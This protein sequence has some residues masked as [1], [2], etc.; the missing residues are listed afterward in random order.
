M[1]RTLNL[2][3]LAHVDAGKTTLTER[4]LHTAGVIDEVGSVDHG[5]THTDTLALERRR[6]ITIRSAVVSF[7]LGDVTVNLVDTPGHSDFIAEVERALA[8]LDGAVLVVSA[9]EGVQAQTRVLMRVLHRLGIPTLV[10]VNKVDRAGARPEAVLAQIADRLTPD[11]VALGEVIG[12]GT[13]GARVE[14]APDT[15]PVTLDRLAEVLTRHDD[16]LL[17]AWLGD[18]GAGDGVA[19][20]RLRA[21]LA[22]QTA[23]VRVH[24]VLFGSAATGAGVAELMAALTA[25]LPT[26]AGDADG[27]VSGTVFKVERGP[28]GE[29]LAWVRMFSGT[30][31]VRDRLPV[32][33]AEARV[34]GIRV[35][36]DG[37]DVVSQAL[38][39]G[40]VGVLTGLTGARVGDAV[41]MPWAGAAPAHHFSPPSLEAVVE[42]CD[43]RRRAA[44]HAALTELCEQD[45]MV[46]L[47]QDD[48]RRELSVSLYGEVQ[49]EVLAATLADDYGVPVGF[50][51]TTPLC[52]ERVLGAGAAFELI[53]VDP[54]PFLATVGLA[55]EPAPV[56]HGVDFRLGVELG[57]MPPAFFTAVEG[58]LRETLL[59]GLH[60]WAVPDAVVTMTHSG[61]WARQS[62]AHGTFDAS[63]SS[64]AGDFRLLTPLVLATALRR[65]GT[66]VCEPVHRFE[67]EVPADALGAVLALLSRAQAVPLETQV[68]R[69][70]HLLSGLVPAARVHAL[71]QQLPGVSRGEG[72]L[73]DAFDHHEPVRGPAPE[74]ARTDHNPLDRKGYLLHTVRRQ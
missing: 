2:G 38:A 17:A 25:L 67:V 16:R 37:D 40:R 36:E 30:L 19:P 9:V 44:L 68:R 66:V 39:A 45:P 50:R 11:A 71:R 35:C 72:V 28:A 73:V 8:V 61:Y 20:A 1:A 27:P 34:T 63:M 69:T 23:A 62:H 47:R 41:G 15:D 60:G 6:G 13:R 3:I 33:G 4:L 18:D 74:R 55:I 56:G 49:K 57:S 48:V 53:D 26:A 70:A 65:A 12:A 14:R 31:R 22:E 59:Q 32:G 51:E 24:P 7:T 29:R 21:A 52:V 64:T 58:A 46:G 10:F 42:P 54:N 5:T 43:P